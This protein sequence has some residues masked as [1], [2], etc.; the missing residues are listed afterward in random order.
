MKER[1]EP[2]EADRAA[3]KAEW[4]KQMARQNSPWRDEA[5]RPIDIPT[6]MEK[7]AAA[8]DLRFGALEVRS[9]TLADKVAENTRLTEKVVKNSDEILALVKISKSVSGF[10]E[11]MNW[12]G[13]VA[14]DIL[15]VIAAIAVAATFVYSQFF[16]PKAAP[17]PPTTAPSK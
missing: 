8:A 2:T 13:G 9:S 7:F 1:F 15:Y 12:L 10:R 11:T 14:K 6:V 3:W 16:A 4:E 17:T 5:G